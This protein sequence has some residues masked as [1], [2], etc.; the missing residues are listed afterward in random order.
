MGEKLLAV[1]AVVAVAVILAV[2]A[3]VGSREEPLTLVAG[4]SADYAPF[5][6]LDA[7][8]NLAGFDYEYGQLLCAALAA[9]CTWQAAPFEHIFED[10]AAGR[11]DLVVNSFTRTPEREAVV[12]FSEPYYRSYGQFVRKAGSGAELDGSSIVALERGAVYDGL[13]R[14]PAYQNWDALYVDGQ[15]DAFIAVAEGRAGLTISDDTLID[16]VVNQSPYAYGGRLGDFERVGG[17]LIPAPGSAEY[18]VLGTGEIGI[19]MPKDRPELRAAVNA[20]IQ[21][22]NAGAAVAAISEKYF[23]R[24]IV[25]R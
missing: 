17:P 4:T 10:T 21:E 12:D 23:G 14:L 6:Y 9:D 16:L 11:Y 24:N 19:I 18:T 15:D 13:L 7:A 2:G 8:G 20:A 1:L 5:T 22:V 3:L 25:A